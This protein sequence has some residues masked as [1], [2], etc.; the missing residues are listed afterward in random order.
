M[1]QYGYGAELSAVSLAV[2]QAKAL[3][4]VTPQ[5]SSAL[6]K[7]FQD[8][9]LRKGDSSLSLGK[10]GADGIWGTNTTKALRVIQSRAGL[11]AIDKVDG[12]TWAALLVT[13]AN[14]R[15]AVQAYSQ[16]GG[17]GD[18]IF[19]A[20]G[21]GAG[22]EGLLSALK[23]PAPAQQFQAGAQTVSNDK[24]EQQSSGSDWKTYA[25]IAGGVL[26]V[27]GAVYLMTRSKE[28]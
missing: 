2:Q 4:E 9:I 1:S 3:D 22:L 20:S 19:S 13:P 18:K 25:L 21:I 12:P 27:G 24:T 5:S 14:E 15:A 10:A 28:D 17:G 6:I 23:P 8:A 7:N 11:A 26:L 16:G